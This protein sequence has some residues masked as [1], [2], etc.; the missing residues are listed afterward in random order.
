MKT[1]RIVSIL[2]FAGLFSF[3]IPPADGRPVSD[4]NNPHNLSYR[5]GYTRTHATNPDQPGA[6]EICIFCHTPHSASKQGALWNRK[7]P[8]ELKTFPLYDSNSLRIKGIPAAQYNSTADYPNGASKLCLSC[9]DGVIGIG[10]LLD[11][12]ITMNRTMDE[13]KKPSGDLALDFNPVIDLSQTHPVSFV[14][15]TAVR[16]ELETLGR[17]F[18]IPTPDLRDSQER[19]QC[20]TCHNPHDDRGEYSDVTG[21]P[22][23][24]FWRIVSATPANSY[25]DLCKYCHGPIVEPYEHHTDAFHP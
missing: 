25:D 8:T 10:T 6:K 5:E 23:P 22:V 17:N 21:D 1:T 13:A 15:S 24:P 19:V 14:Y 3:A 20:T 4:P 11:R 16:D 18:K 9:H 12:E 7:D 2:A